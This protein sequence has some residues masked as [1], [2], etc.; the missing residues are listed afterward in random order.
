MPSFNGL[1]F[2][3]FY[4]V[5]SRR[6]NACGKYSR[7]ESQFYE[8]DLNIQG[9]LLLKECIKEFLKV[10]HFFLTDYEIMFEPDLIHLNVIEC[11]KT[12]MPR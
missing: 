10:F 1:G 8:L 2:C 11:I 7:T 6:C 12:F 5:L 3:C 9:H 4:F